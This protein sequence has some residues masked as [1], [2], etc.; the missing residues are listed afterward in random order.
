MKRRTLFKLL[1]TIPFLSVPVAAFAKNFYNLDVVGKDAF[2]DNEGIITI[3]YKLNQI[4]SVHLD[5]GNS[6]YWEQHRLVMD[7][8]HKFMGK[9]SDKI[10]SIHATH[11]KRLD[12]FN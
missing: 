6:E 8:L 12:G 1:S 4:A 11:H 2:K 5:T 3:T 9:Y 7:G 10:E